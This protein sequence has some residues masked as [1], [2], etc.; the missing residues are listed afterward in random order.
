MS[1]NWDVEF[2][3][4]LGGE[5]VVHPAGD[6]DCKCTEV[7]EKANGISIKIDAEGAK[8]THYLHLV[9]TGGLTVDIIKSKVAAVLHNFGKCQ[10]GDKITPRMLLDLPGATARVELSE[11]EYQSEKSGEM[12]PTNRV[13]KFLPPAKAEEP[14]AIDW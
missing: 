5:W 10:K 2:E 12:V 14:A 13:V 11:D 6:Y 9:P 7:E 3:A 1:I 4:E 8:V